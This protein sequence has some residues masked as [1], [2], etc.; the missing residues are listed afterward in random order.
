MMRTLFGTRRL[1]LALPM[2]LFAT[3]G[4]TLRDA[5]SFLHLTP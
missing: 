1:L 3:G 4:A 5:A 2:A